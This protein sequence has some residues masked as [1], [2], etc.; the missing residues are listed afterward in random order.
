MT[1]VAVAENLVTRQSYVRQTL[2]S[3]W[4]NLPL[5]LLSGI[6]FSLTAL[7]GWHLA[8]SGIPIAAALLAVLLIVPAW[9]ALLAQQAEIARDVRTGIHTMLVAFPRFWLRSTALALIA[10][11]QVA[12]ALLTWPLVLAP[13][14]SP[15]VLIGFAADLFGLALLAAVSLYAFPLIVVYNASVRTALRNALILASRHI[16]NTLGLLGMGILCLLG[17]RSVSPVLLLVLPPIWGMFLVNNCRMVVEE[18]I[19]V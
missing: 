13:E 9:S 2:A 12:V 16:A 6:L 15:I 7:L 8:I 18:E 1:S 5:V 17:I 14:A 11:F 19:G 10:C 4:A 3:T